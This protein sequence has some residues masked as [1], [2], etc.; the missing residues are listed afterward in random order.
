VNANR[1]F[2]VVGKAVPLKDAR[3]KVCGT[4]KYPVDFALPGMVYG[5]I[6]R[7]EHAHALIKR[8]DDSKAR[9]VPGYV[10]MVTHEDA[11]DLDWHGVWLNYIGHIM[12][13]RA[14]FHGDEIGAVAAETPWAA[15]EALSLIEVE[16]EVL[17]AVFD[18]DEA[19]RPD[20]P[21]VQAAGNA[22]ESNVYEWGD[23][24]AGKATA[25]F[26]ASADVK[27]G[28]QQYAPMGRNAALAEWNGDK[29]TLYTGS[30]SP[31][32]LRDGLAQAFG[33]PQSKTRVVSLPLGCSFGSWW[34]NNFMMVAPLLAKK[35]RR[36]VKIELT[37][38]ECM[39]HVKR[40]HKEHSQVSMGCSKDG[41]VTFIDVYHI[42]DNGAYGF[43]VEV[44][45][46][47]IDSWGAR[48]QSGRYECQGVSTNL[49]T[50]GCMRGVGDITMGSLVE[51]CADQLAAQCGIDPVEFRIMNQ[52]R[53]GD[54]LRQTWG[55]SLMRGSEDEWRELISRNSTEAPKGYLAGL[56]HLFHLSSGSSE[57][58]LR[59]GAEAFGWKDKF[60]GWGKPYFVDGPK[61]RAVGVGTGI[62]LCGEEMEGQTDAVVRLMKD[63]SA[64][65]YCSVG[66][67]GTGA[68]TT[69][70]QIAAEVLGLS[71]DRVETECGDSD[72]CPWSRGSLAST[73]LLRTG[74]KTWAA[75]HDARRQLLK[76]AAQEFFETDDWEKLDIKDGQIFS[77]DPGCKLGRGC[78][79]TQKSIP[80]S[81]VMEC[82]RFDTL[83]PTDSITGRPAFPMP[84]S[85]AFA[86]H[87]AAQFVDLE[88]DVETGEIKLL[89]YVVGQDSGTIIN[90][91][92]FAGQIV[93][94]AIVGAGFTLCELLKF[95]D[96]GRIL[97]ANLSDYKV[98]RMKDWPSAATKTVFGEDYDPV[99]PFGARSGG[100]A[101]IAAP[102]V[103]I[104]QA[105]YNATGVWIEVPMTPEKV[106]GAL[107]K[108]EGRED[109]WCTVPEQ[110][111]VGAPVGGK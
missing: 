37:N 54:P 77:T 61:R 33:I 59:K 108:A 5:K 93:G 20:A 101:P 85:T 72:A 19:L 29:V 3:E 95:D 35:V 17:P 66:R 111:P 52:I 4:L 30:Q 48:A 40:R 21:Q 71:I 78:A 75:A 88:V 92:V 15:E 90:P 84:P 55:K 96:E 46:F 100:E 98:M 13:G 9:Q 24:A 68:D 83:G 50:G 47:N 2:S 11:P 106:L 8:I 65:V 23:L 81:D 25:D 60:V 51:R 94:G 110:A 1:D 28:S 109:P 105:V 6:I 10:G 7:S 102:P 89:D 44:G 69:Q 16:Y 99:G 82:M 67:H 14:R 91:G 43:K 103:A 62:H 31:S 107:K 12:D 97:N 80:I 41:K 32:E 70:A 27:F 42:M 58:I 39:A 57:E 34:S 18:E 45:Y 56:P 86:R 36:P 104:A 64:K 76:L 87:F 63:G 49:V 22:R 74:F 53:P 26:T 38:E 73:T 79:P